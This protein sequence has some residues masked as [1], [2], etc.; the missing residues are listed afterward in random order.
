ML[1]IG[2]NRNR[3][4]G[5][6][7]G[8]ASTAFSGHGHHP[9]GRR[10]H[11]EACAHGRPDRGAHPQLRADVAARRR[12]QH[13]DRRRAR[14]RRRAGE[15]R[16]GQ[17][18]PASGPGRGRQ[19]PRPGGREP[20]AGGHAAH[21]RAR[22]Q[23]ELRQDHAV[24]PADRLEPARGQLSRR[25]GGSQGRLHQGPS[26]GARHRP[27]G[28]LLH[29]AVLER[30]GGHAPFPAGRAPARHR[31][32]RGRHERR[33]QPVPD[34]AAHGAGHA[35]GAGPQHDGRGGGQRRHHPT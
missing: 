26:R 29:V 3:G 20:A 18:R 13:R 11:G 12:A 1:P 32:H 14:R 4:R 25:D 28:H 9:A 21:L 31:Q 27:A 8:V 33:A 17:A 22:G 35:H 16:V 24:Q 34:D 5:G 23:P 6:R 2:E 10:D 7:R 19:V 30:G 15:P